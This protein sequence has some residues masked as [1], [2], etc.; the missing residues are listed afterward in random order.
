MM[1][2]RVAPLRLRFSLMG[3]RTLVARTISCRTPCNALPTKA[4]LSPRL[5]TSAVSMK[6]MPLSRASFTIRVV[7][8]CPRLPMFILPPNCIVPSATS[9]TISPVFP[10]FLYFISHTPSAAN[11]NCNL[12]A[13]GREQ[14]GLLRA[15]NSH[16]LLHRTSRLGQRHWDPK[17][18]HC[19]ADPLRARN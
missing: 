2:T 4:S 17:E 10:N 7:S 3:S 8:S 16:H 15:A 18:N 1:F 9:L 5:Y 12:D 13:T 14:P 11:E 19:P 6:L